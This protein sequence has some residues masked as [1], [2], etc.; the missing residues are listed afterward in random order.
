MASRYPLPTYEPDTEVPFAMRL[1]QFLLGASEQLGQTNQNLQQNVRQSND[2]I[3]QMDRSEDRQSLI[4][5]RAR[6]ADIASRD[7]ATAAEAKGKSRAT[8]NKL[9]QDL[10]AQQKVPFPA[11]EDPSSLDPSASKALLDFLM[12][13]AGASKGY[14]SSPLGIYSQ[15]TGEVKTP[16]PESNSEK[17]SPERTAALAASG[18]EKQ[19]QGITPSP[20]ESAA[21]ATYNLKAETGRDTAAAQGYYSQAAGTVRP[22]E[23][24]PP[25][26]SRPG[27]QIAPG[28]QPKAAGVSPDFRDPGM[29][30][31]VP[32]GG[33]VDQAAR[34]DLA[35]TPAPVGGQSI[36][37]R[38]ADQEAQTKLDVEGRN[39]IRKEAANYVL[40]S[41]GLP[42]PPDMPLD[43][44]L[45]EG[46][47]VTPQQINALNA[48]R[49]GL[50]ILKEVEDSKM[51]Q[52]F[53]EAPFKGKGIGAVVGNAGRAKLFQLE[54][55][56]RGMSEPEYADLVTWFATARPA[57][58]KATGEVGNLSQLEQDVVKE[59][60]GIARTR[61]A[62][63]SGIATYRR[64][65]ERGFRANGVPIPKELLNS[66]Q[67]EGGGSKTNDV[68]AAADAFIQ[69]YMQRSR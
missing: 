12:P 34:R 36:L 49:R 21:M 6:Q 18:L 61:E 57:L 48:A 15:D 67:G 22:G 9:F 39:P 32:K 55:S 46:V 29:L 35:P 5:E 65:L 16:A 30:T 25:M 31:G 64:V 11:V 7:R 58:A 51:A 44:V 53:P 19:K 28:P 2:Y 47:A 54:S 20:D 26:P 66:S 1:A 33:S 45:K 50:S 41:T 4:A 62:F 43:Q 17:Y 10:A 24:L 14:G 56:I 60:M 68:D 37:E 42:P 23:G 40:K 8:T 27:S 52:L 13:K 63:A 59:G 3:E 69:K 38:K